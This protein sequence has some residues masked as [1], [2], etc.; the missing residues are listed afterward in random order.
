[1]CIYMIRAAY[2][3]IWGIIANIGITAVVAVMLPSL[4][5]VTVVTLHA[6]SI[7]YTYVSS[8]QNEQLALLIKDKISKS[9]C[10]L[11]R[12]LNG[13]EPSI[14]RGPFMSRRLVGF[15]SERVSN[16]NQGDKIAFVIHLICADDVRKELEKCTKDVAVEDNIKIHT[17][18]ATFPWRIAIN[19]VPFPKKIIIESPQ[20]VK[21]VKDVCK[22]VGLGAGVLI[23]GFPGS[24][25]TFVS[26]LIALELSK[27]G[28]KPKIL[29]GFNPTKKGNSLEFALSKVKPSK[30]TPVI[31]IMNEFDKLIQKV[32]DERVPDSEHFNISVVDKSDLADFLDALG[33]LQNVV[34]IATTNEPLDW[35]RRKDNAYI[36]RDGRF[37]HVV[38][39]NELTTNDAAE[40][41]SDGCKKYNIDVSAPDF[42]SR[43]PITLAQLSNAFYRCHG[44]GSVLLNRL[45]FAAH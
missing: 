37:S 29:D 27:Q 4:L 38:E 45:G 17:Y 31:I 39:L 43:E 15:M 34:F 8:S 10:C 30:K 44:D 13:D 40:C 19:P 28:V 16:T 11:S 35:F 22:D 3:M 21:I 24:G 42:G 12:H 1:M 18:D 7:R 26:S 20:Q 36:I 14:G 33:K 41:F 25:K 5:F 2:S 32:H 23:S 9:C 6:F